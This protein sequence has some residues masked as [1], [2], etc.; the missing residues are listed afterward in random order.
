MDTAIPL[1]IVVNELVS[2]SLKHAF[3]ENKNGE[4][5]IKFYQDK[6]ENYKL[7]IGDNGKGI[8]DNLDFRETS[9]LG[10]ELVNTLVEQVDGT[11]ELDSSQGTKFTIKF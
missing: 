6:D 5:F 3:S 9:S 10:L 4:V 2:N 1:G 11:I 7:I 8:P